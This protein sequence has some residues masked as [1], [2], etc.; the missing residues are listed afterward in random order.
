[1]IK[2]FMPGLSEHKAKKATIIM[3]A[4]LAV[5]GC[6]A[7]TIE[8]NVPA[9]VIQHGY[10]EAYTEEIDVCVSYDLKNGGVCNFSVPTFNHVPERFSLTI[11]QCDELVRQDECPTKELQVD[12]QQYLQTNDGDYVTVAENGQLMR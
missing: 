12:K 11:T 8:P 6:S 9:R 7:R 3:L 10:Y 5:A 4:G 1:M 2:E